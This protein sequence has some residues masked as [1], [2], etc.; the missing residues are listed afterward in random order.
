M[1]AEGSTLP[2]YWIKGGICLSLRKD[3]K[4][5]KR[6]NAVQ[7]KETAIA[8]AICM[9]FSIAPCMMFYVLRDI[10]SYSPFSPYNEIDL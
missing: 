6:R 4:D 5:R 3:R 8:D 10:I 2:K 9:L 1:I 7:I